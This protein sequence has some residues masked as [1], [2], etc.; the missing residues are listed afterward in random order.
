[1]GLFF[2]VMS[3]PLAWPEIKQLPDYYRSLLDA[4]I[5]FREDPE[6]EDPTVRKPLSKENLYQLL[7]DVHW[8]ANV[9]YDGTNLA[10]TT[11]QHIYGRRT[12]VCA[13]TYQKCDITE[14]YEINVNPLAS[15]ILQ[16]HLEK[17]GLSS[18]I[19]SGVL[20]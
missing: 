14:L 3:N 15:D 13:P 11:D 19:G 4:H 6:N 8:I 2:F 20:I 5:R 16:C 10:L 9:K 18:F 7:F 12:R 17:V 1:M